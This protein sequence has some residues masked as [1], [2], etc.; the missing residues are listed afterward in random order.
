[1]S[2]RSRFSFDFGDGSRRPRQKLT[3]QHSMSALTETVRCKA[4]MVGEPQSGK[5]A[6]INTFLG[7]DRLIEIYKPTTFDRYTTV[8]DF[9][10]KHH[11]ELNVWDTGG[12]PEYDFLRPLAYQDTDVVIIC[13]DISEP[14]TLDCISQR[15]FPEIRKHCPKCPVIVAGCKS[16]LRNDIHVM[17]RL[18]EM[19]MIPVSHDKG[20]TLASQ[21]GA[22]A[23]VESS[24][25]TNSSGVREVFEMAALASIGKLNL[26]KS[27]V[28]LPN[29]SKRLSITESLR[30]RKRAEVITPK[31]R[32]KSMVLD[33][34]RKS[35]LVM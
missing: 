20:S 25:R 22:V 13:F 7:K 23:Y 8:L 17:T 9:D 28:D 10:D 33:K 26:Q 18:T 32:V 35:C 6:L 11:V 34:D 5:S 27:Y 29:E 2:S 21:I 4:V 24:A 31:V 15:W 14:T 1:M 30:F 3:R 12:K 19:K 16:D